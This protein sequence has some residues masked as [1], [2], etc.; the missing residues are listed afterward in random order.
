MSAAAAIN[1]DF[2]AALRDVLAQTGSQAQAPAVAR[3]PSVSKAESV[4]R[5]ALQGATLGFADEASAG[6]GAVMQKL[7]TDDP[8]TLAEIYR[9]YRNEKRAENDTARQ[10]NPGSYLGGQVIGGL[11]T[12]LL[13]GGAPSTALR[14]VGVGAGYG[15]AGAAGASEA[16][17][18]KGDIKGAAVDTAIGAGA[19]AVAGGMGYAAAKGAGA[20]RNW[21]LPKSKIASRAA[22]DISSDAIP[23]ASKSVGEYSKASTELEKEIS[24]TTSRKMQFSPGQ[25]TGSKEVLTAERTAAQTPGVVD[26]MAKAQRERLSVGSDYLGKIVDHVAADPEKLGSS[27]VGDGVAKAINANIASRIKA[28]AE[29]AAPLY[30]QAEKLLGN[31]KIAPIDEVTSFLQEEIGRAV[32]PFEP[33]A[34]PLKQTLDVLLQNSKAG[35]A[36]VGIVRRLAEKW[37]QQSEGTGNL[38]GDLPIAQRKR[39]ASMLSEMLNRSIDSAAES[40]KA[41]DAGVMALREAQ[42]TWA[43]HSQGIDSVATDAV[44]RILGVAEEKSDTIPRVIMSMSPNQIGNTMRI[45]N[46]TDP[47][48]AQQLRGAVLLDAF[49][50][51]GAAVREGQFGDEAAA[52]LSPGKLMTAINGGDNAK[53]LRALLGDDKAAI[54][55]LNAAVEMA[56]R[57]GSGPSIEGSDTFPKFAQFFSTMIKN[58][59]GTGLDD[60]AIGAVKEML[61]SGVFSE[62]KAAE[63]FASREGIDA[64]HALMQAQVRS[65]ASGNGRA[66][67]VKAAAIAAS[68]LARLAQSSESAGAGMTGPQYRAE[69]EVQQ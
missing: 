3:A 8:E 19:G 4:A 34:A 27:E 66:A 54:N 68:K 21:L 47:V 20:V 29:A 22:A 50:G 61:R 56:R 63:I 38:L 23:S 49:R 35:R 14:A 9:R 48:A 32:G 57:L 16:D 10:D 41:S 28:R 67:A 17:L 62:E 39:I 26:K 42:R 53:K 58:A 40:G 18:T 59:K 5:G 1:D 6:L 33:S 46:S 7:A 12:A 13:P 37:G 45:L 51:A 60:M 25:A 69:A 24:A 2:D 44:K 52:M 65:Q 15:A 31:K 55:K 36:D 30:K 64:F 43:E 11:A